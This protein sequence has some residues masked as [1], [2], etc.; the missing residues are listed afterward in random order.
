MPESVSHKP[1]ERSLI[2]SIGQKLAGQP[3]LSS[4]EISANPAAVAGANAQE[5]KALDMRLTN[6]PHSTSTGAI[7]LTT[8]MP[9]PRPAARCHA[10]PCSRALL[11]MPDPVPLASLDGLSYAP[12]LA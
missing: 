11:P 5:V 8:E 7:D 12:L 6:P 3:A 4:P 1:V 9:A 10:P 2:I